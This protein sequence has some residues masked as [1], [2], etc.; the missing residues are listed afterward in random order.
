MKGGGQEAT[1]AM[2][3]LLIPC[4]SLILEKKD[5]QGH[6]EDAYYDHYIWLA[7]GD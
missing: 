2:G 5:K 1:R 6:M 3:I 7:K 4:L